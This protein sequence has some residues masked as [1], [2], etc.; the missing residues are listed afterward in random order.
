LQN[1]NQ[2]NNALHP[3]AY[4]AGGRWCWSVS[5]FRTPF[6]HSE[7]DADVQKTA[8]EGW[9]LFSRTYCERL[10]TDEVAIRIPLEDEQPL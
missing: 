3:R 5:C 10:G 6:G 7:G 4:R 9:S 8:E 2:V 1:K